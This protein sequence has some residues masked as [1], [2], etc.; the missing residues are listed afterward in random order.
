MVEASSSTA[1]R[2]GSR[3]RPGE[4]TTLQRLFPRVDNPLFQPY[5]AFNTGEILTL[6]A[7]ALIVRSTSPRRCR[8]SS[9]AC[10]A[11]RPNAKRAKKSHARSPRS[12]WRYPGTS[13]KRTDA[14]AVIAIALVATM[15]G[16][17]DRT[18]P[19]GRQEPRRRAGAVSS[20]LRLRSPRRHRH[21]DRGHHGVPPAGADR[22]KNTL[23]LGDQMFSRGARDAEAAM[24]PTRGLV[25][26]K[27]KL[28]FH[29][30]N[31]YADVPPFMI[32]LGACGVN[33]RSARVTADADRHPVTPRSLA[34]VQGR[35]RQESESR[36]SARRCR[37][38]SPRRASARTSRPWA[39][40]SRAGIRP[41]SRRFR[42][43]R[44]GAGRTAP[45][46][47]TIRPRYRL[48]LASGLT[49]VIRLSTR[50]PQPSSTTCRRWPTR[51]A[52]GC[53]CCS[54]GTS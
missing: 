29:P 13:P 39:W 33:H 6:A 22:P 36:C 16:S 51:R 38:T 49:D 18:R 45:T 9:A 44:L 15:G 1:A 25:T 11:R 26:S 7:E 28:R 47:L 10:S 50:A 12:S 21:P 8:T 17:G 54:S 52:A 42:P 41:R 20:P 2:P 34:A 46:R 40:C 3:R 48:I 35:R 24:A 32:A 37:R 19:A 5:A 53:C 27:S 31:T 43:S 30:L 23:R 4:S 14:C